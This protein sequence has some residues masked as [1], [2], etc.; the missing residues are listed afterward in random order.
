MVFTAPIV[1]V[2][3]TYVIRPRALILRGERAVLAEKAIR[4][5][6]RA[7]DGL[8]P[9]GRT[10]SSRGSRGRGSREDGLFGQHT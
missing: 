6:A 1:A 2:L 9:H 4:W 8:D 10:D 7:R 3:A 5:A